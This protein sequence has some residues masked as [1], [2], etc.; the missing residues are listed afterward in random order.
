M[1]KLALINTIGCCLCWGL[2]IRIILIPHFKSQRAIIT[3]NWLALGL[4]AANLLIIMPI[5]WRLVSLAPFK[6]LIWH[7]ILLAIVIDVL[8][9]SGLILF[10]LYSYSTLFVKWP[11][12]TNYFV[13]LGAAI[14]QGQVSPVLKS[15]LD[16]A[17]YCWQQQPTAFIIVSGGRAKDAPLSEA[18]AMSRYLVKCGIPATKIIKEPQ[19]HNTK[20]N[21]IF[22]QRLIP[23]QEAQ[24]TVITSDFHVLRAKLDARELGLSWRFVGSQTPQAFRPLTF[25]RDYLGVLRDRR[26]FISIILLVSV[27]V[28]E[29]LLT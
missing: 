5:F 6:T 28:A 19:A 9:T 8:S 27:M 1:L 29:V 21:L 11:V 24:V 13:V 12:E 15:R 25:I 16:H 7:L 23:D 20:Q 17:Y 26:W 3:A 10:C 4:M 18:A 2:T 22:S 14:R